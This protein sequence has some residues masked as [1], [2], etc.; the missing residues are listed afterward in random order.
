MNFLAGELTTDGDGWA[1]HA[2]AGPV[3]RVEPS[4][5]ARP[6]RVTLG[7]RPPD[8]ILSDEDR[9]DAVDVVVSVVEPIGS[10]QIVHCLAPGDERLVVVAPIDVSVAA[11][12][13]ARVRFPPEAVHLF[14]EAGGQRL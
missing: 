3:V 2:D 9:P 1:F 10:V 14:D 7:I 5:G 4:D 11:E 13:K 8:A 12:D 6:G